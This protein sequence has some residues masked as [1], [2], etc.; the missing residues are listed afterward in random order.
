MIKQDAGKF[1]MK[2]LDV[3]VSPDA[4]LMNLNYTY[5]DINQMN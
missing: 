4:C 3:D 1:I 5:R 2:Q